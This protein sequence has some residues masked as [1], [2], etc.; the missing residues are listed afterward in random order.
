MIYDLVEVFH[1]RIEKMIAD[2]LAKGCGGKALF[3][4]LKYDWMVKMTVQHRSKEY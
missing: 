3:S 4:K 1:I 2:Y